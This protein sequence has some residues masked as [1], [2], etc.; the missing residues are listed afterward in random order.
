MMS[1]TSTLCPLATDYIGIVLYA[2]SFGS[3]DGC[4]V[5]L[6]AVTTSDIVGPSKLPQALGGLYGTI[7][8]P[9]ILGSPLAGRN[10]KMGPLRKT[11]STGELQTALK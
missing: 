10:N 4:F 5:L 7:A 2:V 1:V 11:S 9:I 8:I 3:F 6:I